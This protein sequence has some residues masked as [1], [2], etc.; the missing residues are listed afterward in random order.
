MQE[1]TSNDDFFYSPVW[2]TASVIVTNPAKVRF[3]STLDPSLLRAS[4]MEME[5]M[6][7][8]SKQERQDL[9]DGKE[10]QLAR[11]KRIRSSLCNHYQK[12]TSR[13]WSVRKRLCGANFQTEDE[14]KKQSR[15]DHFNTKMPILKRT[16]SIISSNENVCGPIQYPLFPLP[17]YTRKIKPF[18]LTQTQDHQ[19]GQLENQAK[20]ELLYMSL[21]EHFSHYPKRAEQ[22][23]ALIK[24]S[25]SQSLKNTGHP[26]SIIASQNRKPG[27][28]VQDSTFVCVS[29]RLLDA[30]VTKLSS[31]T[32]LPGFAELRQSYLCHLRTYTKKFFDPFQ[33]DQVI[34]FE[35][36]C[37]DGGVYTTIG[38]ANF[39]RWVFEHNAHILAHEHRDMLRA[40]TKIPRTQRR[41]KS[42]TTS[43]LESLTYKG[44]KTT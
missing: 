1:I 23:A 34:W 12:E 16:T 10:L 17:S 22:L 11:R 41:W 25:Q 35:L 28:H 9:F 19:P 40:M 37:Q 26:K 2:K 4:P 42:H 39:F 15:L 29:M 6:R 14:Q 18:M 30:L 3:C 32:H 13:E 5:K 21:W 7:L 20:R 44:N 38:Q 24:K 43:T 8:L 36:P 33:R 27:I 31:L